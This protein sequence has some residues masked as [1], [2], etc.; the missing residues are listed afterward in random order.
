MTA[1]AAPQ[2][3]KLEVWIEAAPAGAGRSFVGRVRSA[4]PLEGRYELI[5]SRQGPAGR[6]STRQGGAISLPA[7]GEQRLSQTQLAPLGPD[8]RWE[9]V[10]RILK[11]DA[12]VAEHRMASPP[13]T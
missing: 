13:G 5:A 7:G 3:A 2:S 1:Q 6:S 11:G 10:L 12:V 8:D 9:V 4:Q